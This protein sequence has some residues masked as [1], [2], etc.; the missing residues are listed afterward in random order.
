VALH[1]QALEHFLTAFWAY[2]HEVR[3]YREHSTAQERARLA[4]AFDTL[5]ATQTGYWPW[6]SGLR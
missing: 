3:R 1:Q 6:M 5:F 2:Y 4:A